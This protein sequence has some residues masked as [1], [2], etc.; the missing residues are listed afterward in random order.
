MSNLKKLSLLFLSFALFLQCNDESQVNT[1]Q[2]LIFYSLTAE[3]YTLL[4]GENTKI[5]ATATGSNLNYFWSATRG[6]L[7]GSG[8]EVIYASSPCHVGNNQVTCKIT[9]GESQTE[10]KTISIVVLED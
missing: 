3:K 9:N 5:K 10:S 2:D 1:P 6:D 7:L 8:A 4:P